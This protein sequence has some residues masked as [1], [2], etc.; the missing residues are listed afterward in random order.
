MQDE[1]TDL[2]L[3]PI[4]ATKIST[5]QTELNSIKK[6]IHLDILSNDLPANI[7]TD[8]SGYIRSKM[9]SNRNDPALDHWRQPYQIVEESTEYIIWSN[10][11]DKEIDTNDDIEVSVNKNP[12]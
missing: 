7:T 2:I 10:G 6:V 11:P 8:F 4:N 12:R 9:K 5:V 3:V 1:I